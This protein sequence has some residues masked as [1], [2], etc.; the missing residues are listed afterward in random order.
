M[1]PRW[2]WVPRPR[3]FPESGTGTRGG[4]GPCRE[5]RRRTRNRGVRCCG[6]RDPAS[7][8]V[9]RRPR[10]RATRS[11]TV[12]IRPRGTRATRCPSSSTC[13]T[14]CRPSSREPSRTGTGTGTAP[15]AR[16]GTGLAGGMLDMSIMHGGGWP[17]AGGAALLPRKAARAPA[18][19]DCGPGPSGPI[20][21]CSSSDTSARRLGHGGDL[22]GRLAVNVRDAEDRG[23]GPEADQLH[24]ALLDPVERLR[25]A[26]GRAQLGRGKSSGPES[27]RWRAAR[28]HRRWH[29]RRHR[30]MWMWRCRLL[31]QFLSCCVSPAAVQVGEEGR[32]TRQ[33]VLE[34][35]DPRPVH[36]AG[37]RLSGRRDGGCHVFFFLIWRNGTPG[38]SLVGGCSCGYNSSMEN[39]LTL[40]F[41][42]RKM[43]KDNP[44]P[45]WFLTICCKAGISGSR[46]PTNRSLSQPSAFPS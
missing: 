36:R 14:P 30:W 10:P 8:E 28:R 17:G 38:S 20:T 7:S 16:R 44:N 32:R 22:E 35:R 21:K 6:T 29:R 41:N 34:L 18:V 3:I 4:A 23:A 42:F 24:R 33:R 12:P 15:K 25:R 39:K 11:G 31:M 45:N 2:T 13:S 37:R 19:Q 1:P 9:R 26:L 43:K 27:R 5:S 46:T 40:Y